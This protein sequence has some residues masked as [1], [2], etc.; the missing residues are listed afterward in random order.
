MLFIQKILQFFSRTSS[1]F[2]WWLGIITAT[3][4]GIGISSF[5]YFFQI[6]EVTLSRSINDENVRKGSILQILEYAKDYNLFLLSTHSLEK[7][8]LNRYKEIDS[9]SIE[10]NFPRSLIVTVHPDELIVKWVYFIENKETIFSGFLT[11]ENIFLEY[12]VGNIDNIPTIVDVEARKEK[13]NFYD[14][15]YSGEQIPKILESKSLLEEVIQRKIVKIS[16]LRN[17][18]EVHFT[19][20]KDV[21]YWIYLLHDTT[22]QIEKLKVMLEKKNILLGYLDYIDLRIQNK[23]IYK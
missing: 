15:V 13:I 11:K 8:I 22:I 7:E 18:Q 9:I 19:D 3:I 2:L 14:I 12:P 17:A 21:D 16:Y 10:K 20:E 4:L 23:V 6:K 5:F 1:R